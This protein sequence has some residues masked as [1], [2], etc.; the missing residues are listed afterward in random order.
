MTVLYGRA[1]RLIARTGEAWS[2][3]VGGVAPACECRA[4][5]VTI[6]VVGGE[7]TFGGTA[8]YAGR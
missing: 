8:S 2:A 7:I 5:L 4:P 6:D 1:G 3:S